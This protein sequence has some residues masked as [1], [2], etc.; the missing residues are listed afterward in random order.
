MIEFSF[1]APA[2]DQLLGW[3]LFHLLQ[4]ENHSSYPQGAYRLVVNGQINS[5]LHV[6]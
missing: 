3:V 6:V 4:D 1:M 5:G 2:V